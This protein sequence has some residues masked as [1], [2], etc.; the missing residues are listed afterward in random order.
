MIR[1]FAK[2]LLLDVEHLFV[3]AYYVNVNS[4]TYLFSLLSLIKSISLW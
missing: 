3:Q 4:S 1:L 2:Y